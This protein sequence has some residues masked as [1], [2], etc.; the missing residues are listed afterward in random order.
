MLRWI[1]FQCWFNSFSCVAQGGEA[2]RFLLKSFIWYGNMLVNS[3]GV[4]ESIRFGVAF[5][6]LP[7]Y[8]GLKTVNQLDV[9]VQ[10]DLNP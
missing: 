4:V 10:M 5:G 8:V 6:V 2:P 3:A 7:L 1:P 9:R